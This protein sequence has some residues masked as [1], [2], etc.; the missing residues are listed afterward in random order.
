MSNGPHIHSANE[1]QVLRL[2]SCP[3]SEAE[4]LR[5]GVRPVTVVPST[6]WLL[7]LSKGHLELREYILNDN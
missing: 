4:V 5:L 2:D 1:A 6:S 3:V 7:L